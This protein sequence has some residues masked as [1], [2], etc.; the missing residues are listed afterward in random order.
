V[1]SGGGAESAAGFDWSFGGGDYR[2]PSREATPDP[3]PSADRERARLLAA[4][5]E[6]AVRFADRFEISEVLGEGGSGTV[7]RAWDTEL[8]REVALKVLARRLSPARRE[9][10]R[11]EGELTA[12]LRH[13]GIVAIHTAGEADGLPY[14]AYEL[15]EGG[16]TLDDAFRTRDRAGRLALI[17]AAAD[18]LGFAHARGVVH[19]DVKPENVLVDADGRV[20]VADFGLALGRGRDRLTQTGALVGTPTHMAPEQFEPALGAVGPST[21]VWA[22]GVLLY[23]ALTDGLPFE[24]RTLAQ[25]GVR[26][27]SQRPVPPRRR[28]RTIPRALEDVCLRALATRPG[29]RHPDAA[30]FGRGLDRALAGSL[31]PAAWAVLRR[32]RG[33]ALGLALAAAAALPLGLLVAD[34]R[35]RAAREARE[36][37]AARALDAFARGELDHAELEERVAAA[38]PLGRDV[39]A[40]AARALARDASAPWADRLEHATRALA[41]EPVERADL[42]ALRGRALDALGRPAAAAEAYRAALAAGGPAALR[43]AEARALAAAGR[44]AAALDAVRDHLARARGDPAGLRLEVELALAAGRVESAEAALRALERVAGGPE[45]MLLRAE[46]AAARGEDPLPLLRRTARRALTPAAM[47]ALVRRLVGAGE[48]HEAAAWLARLDVDARVDAARLRETTGAL[49]AGRAPADPP[50]DLELPC[51]RWLAAAGERELAAWELL[52]D[53]GRRTFA[54]AVTRAERAERSGR[55]LRAAAHLAPPEGPLWRRALAGRARL[56]PAGDAVRRELV[57]RLLAGDPDD[58]RALLLAAEDRLA[59]DDPG[60]ALVHLVRAFPGEAWRS[61]PRVALRRGEALLALGRA[62]PARGALDVAAGPER[63]D[64]RGVRALSRAL[65]ALGDPGAPA[66][67][68]RAERLAGSRREEARALAREARYVGHPPRQEQVAAYRRALELDPLCGEAWY[69]LGRELL[70]D[71]DHTAAFRLMTRGLRLDPPVHAEDAVVAMVDLVRWTGHASSIPDRI[72]SLEG[73]TDFDDRLLRAFLASALVEYGRG[74]GRARWLPVAGEA[75]DDLIATRPGEPLPWILRGFV[76]V[77]RGLLA[78]AER[79]LDLAAEAVPT[80]GTIAFYRALLRAARR[81]PAAAVL[82]ALRRARA[83]RYDPPDLE[84][85]AR[86]PEL[87]PY[88]DDPD[89]VAGCEAIR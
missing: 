87:T 76:H 10:F 12:E 18:A 7:Y 44:P 43:L 60:G 51:A 21:D 58:A 68:E 4:S 11:R 35:G 83:L 72:R 57:A 42:E 59:A 29:D 3:D 78:Q 34:R 25:L 56:R 33:L 84:L 88:L 86:Y 2:E 9:R 79:D 70:V 19:R 36:A 47:V 62:G 40:A 52:G 74:R 20:R 49:L 46:V 66:M 39:E 73:S 22:L 81:E 27:V 45:V 38:A 82:E 5:G 53:P 15:V 89:F 6:G 28:D 50:E 63:L 80:S 48:V 67:A 24:A 69:H 13:P 61:E 55:L 54:G 1:T 31:G 8:S 41:L 23:R 32:R 77:R 65:A 64:A 37:A 85:F 75:L 14:L 16:G 30:A 71:G 17:R 26:I